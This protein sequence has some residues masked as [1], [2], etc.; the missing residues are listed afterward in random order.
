MYKQKSKLIQLKRSTTLFNYSENY[1]FIVDG[2]SD[3]FKVGENMI[4]AIIL[5]FKD[6]ALFFQ[7]VEN[8]DKVITYKSFGLTSE[9]YQ[10]KKVIPKVSYKKI[11]RVIQDTNVEID[12]GSYNIYEPHYIFANLRIN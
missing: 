7:A 5:N 8:Y 9:L 1:D 6:D 12:F 2:N 3:Y 10:N 11:Q 4:K